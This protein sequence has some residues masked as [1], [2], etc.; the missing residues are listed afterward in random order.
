MIS[1]NFFVY[2]R[3]VY[4]FMMNKIKKIILVEIKMFE[5]I[6]LKFCSKPFFEVMDL[7]FLT[8]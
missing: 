3:I 2:N 4:Y 8:K 7:S 6:K 5:Y 1:V